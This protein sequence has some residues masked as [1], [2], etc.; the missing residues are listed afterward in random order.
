MSNSEFIAVRHIVTKRFPVARTLARTCMALE[1]GEA[2]LVTGLIDGR[3]QLLRP[4]DNLALEA[5]DRA[6]A[7][8]T[9]AVKDS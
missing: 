9:S 5:D 6:F 4:S 2:V 1:V 7:D 8:C 3:V